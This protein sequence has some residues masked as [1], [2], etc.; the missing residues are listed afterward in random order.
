MCLLA[1]LVLKCRRSLCLH[2]G[3]GLLLS[4][5]HIASLWLRRFL[6]VGRRR[7]V[8]GPSSLSVW[9]Q[10]P[11]QSRKIILLPL[12]L[13]HVHLL[14]FDGESKFVMSWI[15]F[16]ESHI[17]SFEVSSQFWVL[18]SCVVEHCRSWHLR[19]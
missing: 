16:S 17:G 19:M 4:C 18:C 6:W 9:S 3:S 13:L 11:W 10:R 8:F 7:V 2:P 5:F 12:G 15:Y 14:E 1:A